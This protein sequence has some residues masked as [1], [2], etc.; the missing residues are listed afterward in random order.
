MSIE[1]IIMCSTKVPNGI[2]NP[3][4]LANNKPGDGASLPR[5]FAVASNYLWEP[6]TEIR[7]R[8]LEDPPR[9]PVD[10]IV[11]SKIESCAREWEKYANIKLSFGNHPDAEIRI[12]F[13]SGENGG[14]WSRI[15]T[16]CKRI[17]KNEPTM[18]YEGFTSNTSE[19]VYYRVVLHEFGHA[20][21]L[22][23]EHQGPEAA[24]VIKWNREAV[25]NYYKNKGWNEETIQRN[26]F[27]I[28]NSTNYTHFDKES[29]MVYAIDP[30]LTEDGFFVEW[31]Y[32]LSDID[33][34]FIKKIYP[35]ISDIK[36]IP[37]WFGAENQG[38]GIAIADINGNGNVDLIVYH[39]DNPGG[40]N[41]GYYRIGRN[42]DSNGNPQNGWSDPIP[43]PGWFG[44]ENQGGGIAIA[45]LNRNGNVDLIVYHIDNPGGENHGY[46]RIGRDLDLNGNPQSGWSDPI[47]IPGW[48]G[49]E[50]QGGGIAIAD[51]NGNGNVD[52]IVYHID[53]PGGENRGYYRIGR[54]LDLNGNPQSGWSD[55]IPIPGWFGAENQGGGIAIADI[56]GNGNVDLIVYHID[57]PGGENRGY[58][59]IGRDLD[60]NGNPQNGWS[61]PT[62]IP[63]WFGAENQGGGIA[64]A[65]INGNGNVDLIVY[66]IDNP[67]GENHGYYRVL[68][69]LST[70]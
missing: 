4:S 46:Y 6:G 57:N 41:H 61:D 52:L 25:K 23:H 47:P 34:Q 1:N 40:E 38:G 33:K 55:P 68:S 35:Y 31:N 62:P 66:H 18:N 10:P 27:E 53:N 59:R 29:I 8:F 19:S 14:Y 51:I 20:L 64:I 28:N 26:I 3:F 63:G 48:F 69:D 54:D 12:A 56:N 13:D 65:D 16:D 24:S 42:L 5:Y 70:M 60:S 7:V 11:K 39:I 49:A 44:A 30:S 32:K 36:Q 9:I 37:G 67:G 43:I 2:N 17:N 45:D 21:G 58:Y 22:Y 15:G 50:N